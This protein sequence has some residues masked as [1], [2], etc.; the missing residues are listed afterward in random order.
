NGNVK[1][2]NNPTLAAR[3]DLVEPISSSTGKVVASAPV[4]SSGTATLDIENY[5]MPLGAYIKVYDSIG[6]QLASTSNPV[7]IYGGDFYSVNNKD[8]VRFVAWTNHV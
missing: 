5:H 6:N 8:V 2:T 1:V 4:D 7:N 3:V